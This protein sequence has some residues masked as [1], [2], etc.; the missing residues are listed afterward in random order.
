L[1]KEIEASLSL[2]ENNIIRIMEEIRPM[3][4]DMYHSKKDLEYLRERYTMEIE[5][6][7][8]NRVL[9]GDTRHDKRSQGQ[10]HVET[11]PREE[12]IETS[13]GDNIELF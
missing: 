4:G 10:D 9:K 8:H 12:K 11:L 13:L 3:A 2:Q 5:R 6:G 1:L 7:I